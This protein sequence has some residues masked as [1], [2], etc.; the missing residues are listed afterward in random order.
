MR[1]FFRAAALSLVL[2]SSAF[3]SS[4]FA[5]APPVP[6]AAP[7]P[8]V[9]TPAQVQAST[10]EARRLSEGFVAVAERVSPSVVQIDITARDEKADV[11]AHF[12]G[13]NGGGE[14]PIARGMGSG[15]VF[16]PDG[17]ILTNNHVVEE[18]LTINVRLRDGRTMP[19]RLIGRDPATDL[20]VIKIDATGLTPAHFADSDAAR[21]GEWTVAIGSPFGL[22]YTVTAGVLSAKGRGGIGMNAIEDYLQTDA[23][24]NPGNSGGPL[25]NLQ[26]EVLGI[27]TMIVGKGQGIGFA[28]PSNMAQRVAQQ[29]LKSGKVQ[30]AWLGVGVQ[31]LSPELAAAMHLSPGAGALINNVASDGPAFRANIRPG[32]V[33]SGVAGHPVHDGHDLVRETIAQPVGQPVQ[34]EI[35]RSGQHYGASVTLA[36]RPERPVEPTPAQQPYQ[37]HQGLGLIVRDLAPSQAAQMGLPSRALPIVTQVQP[38]SVADREGLRVGDVIVEAN[39]TANP[40]SQQVADA[41]RSGTVL[42]RL[43]RGDAFFYA[44]LKK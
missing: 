13:H 11:L 8:A 28:V 42:L 25:C 9:P 37:P 34:L 19:A 21:V 39:G 16:T 1:F 18:A 35:V 4:A 23:S 26:G 44:A 36:E 5:Q 17:A 6:R 12:F 32:D 2:G 27:N 15:V 29:I 30:R 22:E 43:K 20:A 3:A 7:P 33:V 10:A 40:T 31:D 41:A 38:A 14:E 24:I